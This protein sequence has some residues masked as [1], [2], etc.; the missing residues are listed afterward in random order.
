M[1]KLVKITKLNQI[2]SSILIVSYILISLIFQQQLFDEIIKTNLLTII[3]GLLIVIEFVFSRESNF[4]LLKSNTTSF[5][6]FVLI[7]FVFINSF[8]IRNEFLSGAIFNIIVS[9]VIA[10]KINNIKSSSWLFLIPFWFLVLYILMRLYENPDPSMVFINSRNYISFYLI[11]TVLP[12]YFIQLKH[13]KTSTILPALVT[14]VLSFYSLGRSGIIASIFIFVAIILHK[15]NEK[16]VRKLIIGLI[17]LFLIYSFLDYITFFEVILELE[18]FGSVDNFLEDKG[19]NE[20]I[21]NYLNKIDFISFTFG[22]DVEKSINVLRY[23]GHLHSSLINLHSVV[24]FGSLLF[25][26]AIVKKSMLFRKHNLPLL[27]I[28]LAILI[29]VSTDVGALF[30][31]FDYVFWMFLYYSVKEREEIINNIKCKV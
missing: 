14:L 22:M 31:Y 4:T 11:I 2:I 16:I 5:L 27:F 18:K 6:A 3:L 30:A 29:R 26:F 17:I 13:Q 23:Y 19:R 10:I 12:F 7:V 24:G 20:I 9:A 8:L 15:F 25:F 21:S 28:L 1:E